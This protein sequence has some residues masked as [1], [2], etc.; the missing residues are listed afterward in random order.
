MSNYLKNLFE[1]HEEQPAP[2]MWEKVMS[3]VKHHN[4][5]V[6]ARKIGVATS[7]LVAGGIA[8]FFLLNNNN[9]AVSDNETEIAQTTTAQIVAV[10][11]QSDN[12]AI[13]AVSATAEENTVESNESKTVKSNTVEAKTQ[14][15]NTVANATPAVV[16]QQTTVKEN[17]TV[18]AN[19]V[20]YNVQPAVST[21]RTGNVSESAPSTVVATTTT[22][23]QTQPVQSANNKMRAG[24]NPDTV[25]PPAQGETVKFTMPTAIAP[26]QG[27]NN[28]FCVV[29]DH[30]ELLKSYELS[31]FTRNGLQVYHSKTMTECWDG[32]YKGRIQPM[33][34][35][36][37]VIIYTTPS[38]EKKVEK[39]TVTIVR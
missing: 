36:A 4:A 21:T 11:A 34:A 16:P 5:V 18:K 22:A 26:D 33:G 12:D 8:A 30:P 6:R 28:R 39:G 32:K 27:D 17:E 15:Q 37:Y 3:D 25:T 31:I 9:N 23:A 10:Q 19:T 29:C 24:S 1:N 38:G 7:V 13:A 20:E 2:E 35:Y 14:R